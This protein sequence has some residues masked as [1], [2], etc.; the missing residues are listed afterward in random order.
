MKAAFRVYDSYLDALTDYANLLSNNS[1]YA[2][3]TTAKTAE[4]G[5]HALQ[6]AGYATDPKYA[7]SWWA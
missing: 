2:K 4:E 6:E 1:R 3:V 5:A 7:K